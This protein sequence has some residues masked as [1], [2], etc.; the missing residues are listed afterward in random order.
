MTCALA[1]RAVKGAI[2]RHAKTAAAGVALR[3]HMRCSLPQFAPDPDPLDS[4]VVDN[5]PSSHL[6]EGL[7]DLPDV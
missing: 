3:M 6:P 5:Q 2:A 7:L 4:P 1:S